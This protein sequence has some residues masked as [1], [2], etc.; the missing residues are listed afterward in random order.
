M[1]AHQRGPAERAVDHGHM[2]DPVEPAPERLDLQRLRRIGRGQ[3]GGGFRST[4]VSRASR[5]AITS[6]IDKTASP[7]RRA[8]ALPHV[9]SAR[10]RPAGPAEASRPPSVR[11]VRSASTAASCG[12]A[13]RHRRRRRRRRV[14]GRRVA[15]SKTRSTGR[16]AET[17]IR[18]GAAAASAETRWPPAGRSSSIST[19]GRR[20]AG[21]RGRM[22]QDVTCSPVSLLSARPQAVRPTAKPASPRERSTARR[23]AA[24]PADDLD[25]VGRAVLLPD[26][27]MFIPQ[28]VVQAR[29][30]VRA[31][32]A[33]T[34]TSSATGPAQP[35]ERLVEVALDHHI[36][37]PGRRGGLVGVRHPPPAVEDRQPPPLAGMIR[38]APH[39]EA[40]MV[41]Q[42]RARAGQ[43]RVGARGAGGARGKSG[44]RR[45][46]RAARRRDHRAAGIERLLDGDPGPAREGALGERRQESR[47]KPSARS[48]A[49]GSARPAKPTHAQPGAP[50]GG[51]RRR[52]PPAGSGSRS[53]DPDVGRRGFQDRF[54][55]GRRAAVV[56]ARLERDDE[57]V[58]RVGV[59]L[60]PAECQ[61]GGLGV[62]LA[63]PLDEP[64][65][66]GCD[67]RRRGPRSRPADWAP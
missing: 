19:P 22:L 36:E 20:P 11:R 45:E 28:V 46:G 37:A 59:A 2:L 27:H 61:R 1:Q 39:R 38:H 10:S 32:P 5:C 21:G 67:R 13:A 51:P 66:P 54:R 15:G 63:G 64:R 9:S 35:V 49:S 30:A 29:L 24:V 50:R 31:G 4:I 23:G 56:I 44:G 60:R 3:P 7:S 8:S 40:G 47:G 18:C 43:D 34:S 25:P 26:D 16:A 6:W 14:A 55:A 65:R 53:A 41:G 58:D 17:A 52:R 48:A 57:A 42:D 62:S 33:S 12:P